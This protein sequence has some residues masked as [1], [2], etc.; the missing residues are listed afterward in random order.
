MEVNAQDYGFTPTDT[1][2]TDRSVSVYKC[3]MVYIFSKG[4]LSSSV[5]FDVGLLILFECTIKRRSQGDY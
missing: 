5:V 1:P 2:R 4:F 3:V